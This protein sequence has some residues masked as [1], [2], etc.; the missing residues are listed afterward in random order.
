MRQTFE[1]SIPIKPKILSQSVRAQLVRVG[2][3]P[4]HFHVETLGK[5]KDESLPEVDASLLDQLR[6]LVHSTNNRDLISLR[7]K[8][9]LLARFAFG[10][11]VSEHVA[12]GILIPRALTRNG[13]VRLTTP[14]SIRNGG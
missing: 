3:D 10:R 1:D 8:T 13:A 12:V 14:L 4:A 9:Q 6:R 7:P 2:V 5:L 11:F